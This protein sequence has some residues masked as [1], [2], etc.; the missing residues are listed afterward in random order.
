M[1]HYLCAKAH[2]SFKSRPQNCKAEIG[3]A[4]GDT[5]TRIIHPA[6]YT[7]LHLSNW[8]EQFTVASLGGEAEFTVDEVAEN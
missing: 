7:Q 6:R 3:Q 4:Q 5:L 1:S 2:E 8:N